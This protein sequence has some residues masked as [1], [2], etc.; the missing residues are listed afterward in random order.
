MFKPWLGLRLNCKALFGARDFSGADRRGRSPLM[1]LGAGVVFAFPATM[2]AA[3]VIA[4]PVVVVP[5]PPRRQPN[6]KR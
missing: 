1:L 3:P 5:A 2:N 4:E 6:G